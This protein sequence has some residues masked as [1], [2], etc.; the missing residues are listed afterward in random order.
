METLMKLQDAHFPDTPDLLQVAEDAIENANGQIQYFTESIR[1]LGSR[2]RAI[3]LKTIDLLLSSPSQAD[4]GRRKDEVVDQYSSVLNDFSTEMREPLA[5]LNRSWMEVDQ[6]LG[7]YLVSTGREST[8]NPSDLLALI[9]TMTATRVRI[10]ETIAEISNLIAAIRASA[11][12]LEGLDLSIRNA[13]EILEKLNGELD[14]ADSV[15]LRQVILAERLYG[16]LSQ[17]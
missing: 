6:A 12:G 4:V 5:N 10:P 7:F 8:V 9:E 2:V 1:G 13:T 17:R 16:L 11:G 15:I 3:A 14:L